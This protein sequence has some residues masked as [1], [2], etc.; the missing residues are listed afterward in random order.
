L[1]TAF[2]SGLVSSTAAFLVLAKLSKTQYQS[3]TT[4]VASGLLATNA[5]LIETIILLSLISPAIIVQLLTPIIAMLAVG[6]L[7][8]WPVLKQ[9]GKNAPSLTPS[10]PLDIR[11]V[12]KIAT[13]IIG[14]LVLI[15]IAKRNIGA[16]AV[17]Y[18][19]FLGGLFEVH[20]VNIANATLFAHNEQ[21]LQ[22]SIQSI[23]LALAASFVTKYFIL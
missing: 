8:A 15:T 5:M 9:Q 17:H 1:L 3:T 23:G 16:N 21:S 13:F 14:M 10:N 12:V 19:S 20:S 18:I 6:F 4:L 22:H 7:S 2:F 11:G